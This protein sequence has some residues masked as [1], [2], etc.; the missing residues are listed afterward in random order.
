MLGP[1]LMPVEASWYFTSHDTYIDFVLIG[2]LP[3]LIAYVCLL[4]GT[5]VRLYRTAG[6]ELLSGG[7]ETGWCAFGMIVM[8]AIFGLFCAGETFQPTIASIWCI[9]TGI[10]VRAE[11][12]RVSALRLR[13]SMPVTRQAGL[14][15]GF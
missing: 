9:L 4:L 6:H 12:E 2:G 15:C 8:F 11:F 5:V 13:G 3:L 1:A 10:S 7:G 14:A